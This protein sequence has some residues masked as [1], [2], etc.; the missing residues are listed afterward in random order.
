[1]LFW[2]AKYSKSD[3]I[4]KGVMCVQKKKKITLQFSDLYSISKIRVLLRRNQ[5]KRIL[6]EKFNKEIVKSSFY[7]CFLKCLSD[8]FIS[9][10]TL[11]SWK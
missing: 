6:H 10:L 8:H 5:F 7:K 3:L 9:T 1:M 4:S 11:K 2:V